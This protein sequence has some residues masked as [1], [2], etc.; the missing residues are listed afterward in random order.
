MRRLL[1]LYL[2]L[3]PLISSGQDPRL[4]FFNEQEGPDL[5]DL[6]ADSTL[7]A[8][9]VDLKAEI[10]MGMLDLSDERVSVIRKLN[11]S[12][13]PVVAWLLLPKEKGYWFHSGNVEEAFERY[14][15]VKQWAVKNN[16]TFSGIGIDLELDMN[17]I[18]LFENN[19]FGLFRKVIGRLYSDRKFEESKER[20][21]ELIQ[22]I[23]NDGFSIE[24]YYVPMIRYETERGRTGLQ[25][26]TG[27]MDLETDKDIPMLYTSFIGNAYGTLK[28]LAIDE[29]L[30]YVA[31]GS[32]GGGFDPTLPSM[33]WEDLAY[34]LRLAS[35]VADE[36]H[37]FCLEASVE[38]G[39]IKRLK[40]FDFSVDIEEYPEQEKAVHSLVTNV[41]II[42]ALLSNPTL[43]FIGVIT[44]LV[45]LS[46]GMIKLIGFIRKS[47]HKHK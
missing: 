18:E 35:R 37:I 36:I 19:K 1:I 23:R 32:T 27:F 9:L 39:F 25:Q 29:G 21:N 31:I 26:A 17:D 24:S 4:S 41:M 2:W 22:T 40:E 43:L 14:Y 33:T 15:E 12:Q 45:L 11:A 6:F 38:K 46:I 7:I 13:I 3:I 30:K 42:S 5:Q 47:I 34:D 44:V 8:D 20:Y 16:L 10:R 28:V